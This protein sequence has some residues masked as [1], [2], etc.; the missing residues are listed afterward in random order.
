MLPRR[1]AKPKSKIQIETK[2]TH[3]LCVFHQQLTGAE[4]QNVGTLLN[5]Y[6]RLVQ[7]GCHS[8]ALYPWH[9]LYGTAPRFDLSM[10]KTTHY[11]CE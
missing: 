5:E 11:V 2:K 7:S 4:R 3:C 10:R 8:A 9:H 6:K 1:G